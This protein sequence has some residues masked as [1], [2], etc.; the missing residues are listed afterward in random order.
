MQRPVA[1]KLRVM[2]FRCLVP[3]SKSLML[4]SS[5]W[6]VIVSIIILWNRILIEPSQNQLWLVSKHY[7][8]IF[9]MDLQ[10]KFNIVEYRLQRLVRKYCLDFLLDFIRTMLIFETILYN[11]SKMHFKSGRVICQITLTLWL[12]LDMK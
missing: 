12:E 1:K 5:F 4:V 9:E 3:H 7:D 6:V 10:N 8:L 2:T 11:I